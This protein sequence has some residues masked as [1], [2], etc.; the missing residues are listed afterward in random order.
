MDH[1][2]PTPTT[3][4]TLEQNTQTNPRESELPMRRLHPATTLTPP[5]RGRG[6]GHRPARTPPLPALH[7]P[8]HRRRPHHPRI[9]GRHRR[10][11]QPPPPI[12]PL[13]HHRH[14]RPQH[15]TPHRHTRRRN[16]TNTCSSW[17]HQTLTN[18]QKQNEKQKK[19]SKKILS[20]T[21]TNT[22]TFHTK[23]FSR[24]K[25]FRP[26]PDSPRPHHT[27]P[28]ELAFGFGRARGHFGWLGLG[29]VGLCSGVALCVSLVFRSLC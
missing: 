22:K 18:T 29:R 10:P 25:N 19:L 8:S 14:L 26:G 1:L 3:P 11:D 6:M 7:R 28:G 13:P 23:K 4:Q 24:Q 20:N 16:T 21:K 12:P 17:Q 5:R 2:R 9:P 27:R 15:G